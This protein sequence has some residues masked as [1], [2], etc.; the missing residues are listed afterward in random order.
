MLENDEAMDG[1]AMDEAMDEASDVRAMSGVL[2]DI[3]W[4]ILGDAC[5]FTV[6]LV[7]DCVARCL[8]RR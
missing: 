4:S 5:G 3:K 8:L 1:S 7:A 6:L 2:L